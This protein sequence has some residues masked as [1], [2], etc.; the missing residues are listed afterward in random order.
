[1]EDRLVTIAEFDTVFDA[2]LVKLRLENEGIEAVVVGGDLLANMPTISRIRIQLQVLARDV[3]RAKALLAAMEDLSEE[4]P[5]D[6]E[7]E[8]LDAFG[9]FDD[10]DGE[11]DGDGDGFEEGDDESELWQ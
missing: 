4:E 5:L 7:D 1:M 3:V 11:G 9:G 10:I 8:D 2:E 6:E